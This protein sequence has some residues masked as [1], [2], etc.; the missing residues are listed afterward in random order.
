[1][2]DFVIRTSNL[3]LQF[4][5]KH[6]LSML[7]LNIARGG[8]HA[9]AGARGAGKTALCRV[10]LG[11]ETPTSGTA[12]V[13]GCDST[14]LTPEL[15][16]RIGFIDHAHALPPWLHI[17]QLIALQRSQ[18]RHWKSQRFESVARQFKLAPDQQVRDL[19]A[20]ERAGLNLALGLAQDPELLILDA[21]TAGL[22]P[23]AASSFLEALTYAEHG[24]STTIVY[25]SHQMDDIERVADNLVILERGRLRHMSAPAEFCKL[26]QLWVA[27][28]P[29]REP[30]LGVLPGVLEVQHVDGF[31]HLVVYNQNQD[32]G[33]RLRLL[34]A[35]SVHAMPVSLDRAVNGF[36]SG[37][38]AM[39][40]TSPVPA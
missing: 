37:A 29:Q 7:T 5:R 16:G 25:L 15:R 17:G 24:A 13:L 39:A 1:M 14:V 35:R 22:D 34:G 6:A 3:C 10:L 4:D 32:F 28:F 33:T 12:R 21:P 8:V 26:V 31:V 30:D 9:V 36:L 18:Y 40:A 11:F 23:R 20:G 38:H 19:A 27:D 2:N